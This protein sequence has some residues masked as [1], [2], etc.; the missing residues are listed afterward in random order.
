LSL[1]GDPDGAGPLLERAEALLR[2]VTGGVFLHGAHA[3]LAVVEARVARGE[4]PAAERLL[5]PIRRA[6]A[7]AGWVETVAWADLLHA[8]SRA[9]TDPAHAARLAGG[10]LELAGASDLPGLTWQA[11]ALLALLAGPAG[12]AG[13]AAAAREIVAGLAASLDDPRLRDSYR[14]ATQRRLA[15]AR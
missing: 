7:Q 2:G 1:G 10:V 14:A 3:G 4:L 15:A 12:G 13:H 11:H 9:D 8:R 5:G 6:A